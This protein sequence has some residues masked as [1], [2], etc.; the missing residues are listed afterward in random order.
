M[1][2]SR[3]PGWLCGKGELVSTRTL[4]REG[5]SEGGGWVDKRR[6]RLELPGLCSRQPA[7]TVLGSCT[8][9]EGQERSLATSSST[10]GWEHDSG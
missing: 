4:L 3:F 1:L 9:Q 10:L 7:G 6:D 2:W 8:S 5:K